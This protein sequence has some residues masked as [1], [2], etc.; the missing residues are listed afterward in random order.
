MKSGEKCR[1][2]ALVPMTANFKFREELTR[3]ALTNG[4]S[5]SI[6]LYKIMITYATY[7]WGIQRKRP[8]IYTTLT[9]KS[10]SEMEPAG[11]VNF[12]ALD[13]VSPNL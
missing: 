13:T 12:V 11:S 1:L 9:L 10:S 8:K 6:V 3:T 5:Y 4:S 2:A 7:I